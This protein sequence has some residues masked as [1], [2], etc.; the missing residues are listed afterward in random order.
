MAMLLALSLPLMAAAP[1]AYAS[2]LELKLPARSSVR[3]SVMDLLSWLTRDHP[4]PP[5][6]PHQERGTAAGKAHEVPAA[7]TR[8]VA[9]ARGHRRGRGHGQLPA[10]KAHKPKVRK[11]TTGGAIGA[12][13]FNRRRAR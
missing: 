8:T 12:S 11:Y 6:T 13:H 2:P 10:Y 4:V 1:A 3:S 5:K 9:R 7:A